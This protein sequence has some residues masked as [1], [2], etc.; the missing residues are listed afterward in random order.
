MKPDASAVALASGAVLLWI[1]WA[2]MPDAATNDAAHI[3]SA[4][5][6]ARPPVR[7]SAILQLG[8]AAL[9]VVGLSVEAGE[10]PRTRAGALAT[11]LG[12][13]GMAADAVFHQLAYEMTAP[14]VARAAVLPVMAKMQTDQLRPHV[15]LLL[16]F[17]VGPVILG[18]QRRRAGVGSPWAA[19]LLMA[20]AL[21]IPLGVADVL[22]F[23]A[24]RRIVALATLGA[25]CA[26]LV[27]VAADRARANAARRHVTPSA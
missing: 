3:L 5:A 19:R 12:G 21:V 10:R 4:V 22:A 25:I 7:A 17:L 13:V 15:P 8:G 24:S 27:A 18:A 16:A 11:I 9:L 20:P 2:L 23:D 26:G 1:A 14:G 6:A